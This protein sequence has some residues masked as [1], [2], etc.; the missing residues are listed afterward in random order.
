[1]QIVEESSGDE[2]ARLLNVEGAYGPRY[3]SASGVAW[4]EL[5]TTDGIYQ[6]RPTKGLPEPNFVRGRES[7]AKFCHDQPGTGMH[8]LFTPE[9]EVNDDIAVGRTHFRFRSH[10]QVNGRVTLR[11]VTGIYDSIYHRLDDGWKISQ[12]VTTYFEVETHILFDSY[13]LP[14]EFGALA[15]HAEGTYID[16]RTA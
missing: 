13:Q 16:G 8:T 10:S 5:F 9:I 14:P 6:G 15:R 12:R 7:L 3:D 4:A 2:F 1:M 11:N